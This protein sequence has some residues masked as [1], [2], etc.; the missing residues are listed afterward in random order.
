MGMEMN[1]TNMNDMKEIDHFH[2]LGIDK[3]GT[4]NFAK[5]HW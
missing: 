2:V 3:E 1:G 5:F 4:D